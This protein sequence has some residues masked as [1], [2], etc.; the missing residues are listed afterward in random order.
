MESVGG[1]RRLSVEACDTGGARTLQVSSLLYGPIRLGQAPCKERGSW[2][3]GFTTRFDA[4][5]DN[6]TYVSAFGP[7]IGSWGRLVPVK[8]PRSH[9]FAAVGP[10]GDEWRVIGVLVDGADG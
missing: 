1:K 10:L 3:V 4:S 5:P 7:G 2:E 6:G 8:G 9:F